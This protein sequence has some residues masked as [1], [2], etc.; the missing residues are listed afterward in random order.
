MGGRDGK[1]SFQNRTHTCG[2][3]RQGKGR[4]S[5]WCLQSLNQS[6]SMQP[7]SRIISY[8][9]MSCRRRC[10]ISCFSSEPLRM[11]AL[12]MQRNVAND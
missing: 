7:V 5:P 2:V 12:D 8:D 4:G 11:L 1:V 10:P 6:S 3:I 9:I